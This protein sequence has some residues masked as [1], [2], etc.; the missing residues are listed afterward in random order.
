MGLQPLD[1]FYPFS[2]G[3]DFKRQNLTF[4]NIYTKVWVGHVCGGLA[5]SN[6]FV[7]LDY[8][9]GHENLLWYRSSDYSVD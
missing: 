1:M 3:I 8:K 2:A 9:L 5:L 6:L 7:I 4:I